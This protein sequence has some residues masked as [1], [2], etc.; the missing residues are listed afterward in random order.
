MYWFY[1]LLGS[2]PILFLIS[3]YWLRRWK[4]FYRYAFGNGFL[5][6]SYSYLILYSAIG[7]FEQDPWQLKK[8]FLFLSLLFFHALASFIFAGYYHY[9]IRKN[10]S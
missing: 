9:K 10:E 5:F 4:W 7:F 2:I 8:L 3:F 1:G 6:C